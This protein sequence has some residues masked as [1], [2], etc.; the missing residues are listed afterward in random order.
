MLKKINDEIFKIVDICE[1]D[2]NKDCDCAIEM[3]ENYLDFLVKNK[4]IIDYCYDVDY[5]VFDSCG[6][7]IFYISIAFI[8]NNNT[9]KVTGISYRS[10]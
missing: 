5:D 4:E 3:I 6:L 7:D 9:L 10:Y 1:E 2:E 8:D